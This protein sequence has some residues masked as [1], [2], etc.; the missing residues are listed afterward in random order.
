MTLPVDASI[1]ERLTNDAIAGVSSGTFMV[2]I[3]P[4]IPHYAAGGFHSGGMALV[5]EEGPELVTF[6]GPSRIFS[7]SQSRQMVSQD[8]TTLL[9]ALERNSALLAQLLESSQT[10]RGDISSLTRLFATVSQNGRVLRT[11]GA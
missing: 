11:V 1:G 7:N 6:G 5:G 3:Q 9:T 8:N 10:Q 4:V 2:D